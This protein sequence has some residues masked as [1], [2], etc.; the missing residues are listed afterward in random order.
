MQIFS[1]EKDRVENVGLF[2]SKE[3]EKNWKEMILQSCLVWMEREEINY[4]IIKILF[5]FKND[6]LKSFNW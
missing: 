1:K 2:G 3:I 5:C 4:T 6:N